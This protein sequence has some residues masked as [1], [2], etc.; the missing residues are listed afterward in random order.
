MR[1]LMLLPLAA[2]VL[3]IAPASAAVTKTVQVTR[4]GFS[5]SSATV[6]QGDTVTFHNADTQNHQV[7]ADDGT[8]ASPVLT[9]D[10]T[11]S[12]ILSKTG[13]VKYHDGL[14]ATHK[15]SI[16]VKAPP[17]DVSLTVS[18]ATVVY[19]SSTTLTGAVSTK[20]AAQPVVLNAHAS[21]KSA[22]QVETTTTGS[23][24]SF[25][26]AVAPTIQTVYQA[27]YLTTSSPA[28]TVSVAPR[29]GFG[30]SGRIYTVK[31]TSDA[32]YGGHYTYVQRR[33]ATG[34]WRNVKKVFLSSAYNRAR[35]T[36]LLPRGR[37]Y[38]RVWLPATQAGTGY[39]ESLSRTMLVVRG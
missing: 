31:V 4:T 13:T 8:F 5:P 20:V 33:D 27:Q 1:R 11:Y 28:V 15:G 7:V 25:S 22:Q 18:N 14:H 9:P 10:Q 35:F 26:F 16:T 17:T 21:G 38:L 23:D 34:V 36:M 6:T 29:V 2:L 24:G 32:G 19:G 39:V 3:A 30:L 12:V 37:N